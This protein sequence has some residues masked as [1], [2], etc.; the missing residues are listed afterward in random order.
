MKKEALK[1]AIKQNFENNDFESAM[2]LNKAML[3][4]YEELFGKRG[5]NSIVAYY[6]RKL[7]AAGQ[8]EVVEEPIVEESVEATEAGS[9]DEAPVQEQVSEEEPTSSSE[10]AE[11]VESA[12]FTFVVGEPIRKDELNLVLAAM[13]EADKEEILSRFCILKELFKI[14]EES[15]IIRETS[16]F[17]QSNGQGWEKWDEAYQ[18]QKSKELKSY[19]RAG[20]FD[21][22]NSGYP[23]GEEVCRV[24]ILRIKAA[25]SKYFFY[26]SE[27][28]IEV[29]KSIEEA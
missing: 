11:E 24:Q 27:A 4:E 1:A 10:E 28:A 16:M 22:S 5:A 2:E 19:R 15:N 21:A 6:R 14:D 9:V 20:S 26:R 29:A 18:A 7:D 8:Q 25:L 13:V 12:P 17:I 3:E 23:V